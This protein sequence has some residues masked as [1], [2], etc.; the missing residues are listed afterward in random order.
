MSSHSYGS[1]RSEVQSLVS[2]ISSQCCPVPPY[3]PISSPSFPSV[4][5]FKQPLPALLSMKDR[6]VS[7]EDANGSQWTLREDGEGWLCWWQHFKLIG[8]RDASGGV[9]ECEMQVEGRVGLAEGEG[10]EGWIDWV[11]RG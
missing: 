4:V 1:E 5:T 6:C 9:E 10:G 2:A 8:T 7:L 3:V 11:E